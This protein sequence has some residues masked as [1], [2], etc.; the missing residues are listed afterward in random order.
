M[1]LISD[2]VDGTS[3]SYLPAPVST[4]LN[5]ESQLVQ[6]IIELQR[7]KEHLLQMMQHQSS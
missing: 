6:R 7:E 5:T 2:H 3:D 1:A 4:A